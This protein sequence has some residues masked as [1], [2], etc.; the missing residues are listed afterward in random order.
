MSQVAMA[1]MDDDPHSIEALRMRTR[2]TGL[3][4]EKRG[5]RLVLGDGSVGENSVRRF[6]LLQILSLEEYVLDLLDQQ[7]P[8]LGV[9][10]KTV[11]EAWGVLSPLADLLHARSHGDAGRTGRQLEAYAPAFARSEFIKVIRAALGLSHELAKRVLDLFCWPG[12]ARDDSWSYPL[13]P[14]SDERLTLVVPVL[15]TASLS[16]LVE[17][18]MD[19]GGLDLDQRGPLFE[20]FMRRKCRE[21][22]AE[23]KMLA[24]SGVAQGPVD[25]DSSVGDLDVVLWLGTTVLVCE[26]KC[27]RDVVTSL[28]EH[29]HRG[30]LVHAAEQLSARRKFIDDHPEVLREKLVSLG[31]VGDAKDVHYAIL[32]NLPQGTLAVVDGFPV[33]DVYLMTQFLSSNIVE[34]MVITDAQGHARAEHFETLYESEV[35]AGRKL[36][37]Y[38]VD[39]PH[40]RYIRE[41]AKLQVRPIM[42]LEEGEKRVATVGFSIGSSDEST[43]EEEPLVAQTE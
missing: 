27:H 18:W 35:D 23:N 26:A 19:R 13:I 32:T 2:I 38:L 33:V 39:P 14:L 21:A 15:Q 37:G 8:S 12:T 7:L 30:V 20:K 41:H 4:R 36:P 25:L 11:L 10:L 29:H 42:A 40:L 9:T 3:R 5:L 16:R 43:A 28:E 34:T 24:S 31:Y 17:N 1:H 6:A 22:I